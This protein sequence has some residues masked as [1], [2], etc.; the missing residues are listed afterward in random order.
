MTSK[1]NSRVFDDDQPQ[2]D[3][4]HSSAMA[5]LDASRRTSRTSSCEDMHSAMVSN[6][7]GSHDDDENEKPATYVTGSS[8]KA[9]DLESAHEQTDAASE[10][11]D[12]TDP[13]TSSA[14][15]SSGSSSI[16]LAQQGRM[17]NF[18][19]V[20]PGVYRS[21]YPLA[22]HFDFCQ[23]L[24]L[25]TVVTL[26]NKHDERSVNLR[27]F[28]QDNGINHV[29]FNMQGTKKE[30]IPHHTMTAILEIVHDKAAH[31]LLIH[32]NQGK[33]RTGCVVAA[34]RKV[35]GWPVD[36]VIQEYRTFAEPKVRDCD[37]TYITALEAASLRLRNS[38]F[39]AAAMFN[40]P[41]RTMRR[42][43][44]IRFVAIAFTT[45]LVFMCSSWQWNT[46]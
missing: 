30:S 29:V 43:V 27:S 38:D 20:A 17:A 24:G 4:G 46:S 15:S 39:G 37:I 31:P 5:P 19:V 2:R 12:L 26:V 45:M 8:L 3:R 28:V 35:A 11:N 16:N 32:C 22:E 21:S 36:T 40:N 18:G 41:Y 13:S 25:R 14:I 1:R 7:T 33:H 42:R 23:S 6:T 34:A 44:F 9:V 10:K